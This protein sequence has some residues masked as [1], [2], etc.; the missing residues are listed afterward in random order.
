MDVYRAWGVF[1][2]TEPGGLE[3]LPLDEDSALCTQP[4]FTPEAA[5]KSQELLEWITAEYDKVPT[6][7]VVLSNPDL[8]CTVLRLPMVYGP[9]DYIHRFYQFLKRMDDGRPFILFAENVAAWRTPRGYVKDVAHGIALAATSEPAA[10]RIYNICE[11][12]SFSELE[13]ARK[14]AEATGWKGEFVQLPHEKTPAHLASPQNTAQHMVVSGERIRHE[15]GFR[16]ITPQEEAFRRTI[17]W[18]RVNPPS[19]IAA[20]LNYQA[21]DEALA[22]LKA[23]A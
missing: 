20:P 5:K 9:G 22:A 7:R 21:E 15:L 10:G 4:P 12:E 23:T 8:P 2:G 18:E 19:M 16:E 1:Q 11:T 14:I 6:E 17:E 3:E 13:W